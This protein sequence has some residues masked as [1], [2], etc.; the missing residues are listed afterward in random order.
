MNEWRECVTVCVTGEEVNDGMNHSQ[1]SL[2]S[3]L[4][5]LMAKACNAHMG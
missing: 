4:D 2:L 1:A 3:K 5:R